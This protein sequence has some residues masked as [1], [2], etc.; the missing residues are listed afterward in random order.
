MKTGIE[1]LQSWYSAQC[2]GDWEHSFGI[3]IGTLDNPGW[4]VDIELSGTNLANKG[5]TLID[6][7]IGDNDWMRCWVEK[8]K[9]KVVS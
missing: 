3:D 7:K 8:L 5:F 2:N 1:F 9:F 6:Q 4:H